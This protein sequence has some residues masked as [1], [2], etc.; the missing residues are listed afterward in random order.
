MEGRISWIVSEGV[1]ADYNEKLFRTNLSHGCF[2]GPERL[3]NTQ[4]LTRTTRAH[5]FRIGAPQT[6][7]THMDG[8]TNQCAFKQ[9]AIFFT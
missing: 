7:G 2:T 5:H 8:T 9:R 3:A 4:Q 6:K 1:I